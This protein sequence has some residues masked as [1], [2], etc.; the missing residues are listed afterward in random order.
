MIR[1]SPIVVALAVLAAAACGRDAT[2]PGAQ[3]SANEAQ[4]LAANLASLSSSAVGSASTGHALIASTPTPVSWTFSG[5]LPCPEGGTVTPELKV[6]GQVDA[7]AHTSSFDFAGSSTYKSCASKVESG[8]IAVTGTLTS[9]AHLAI[10]NLAPSGPETFTQK[11]S[12]DWVKGDGTKG[13]CTVDLSGSMD[14]LTRKTSLTGT[15]CG[16]ALS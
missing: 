6:I 1:K 15:F 8:T 3:L 10:A 14:P 5:T 2:A 4:A 12:F 7:T 9:S 16:H 13:S 11:G